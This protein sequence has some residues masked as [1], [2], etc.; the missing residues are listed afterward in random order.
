M[1]SCFNTTARGP[2]YATGKN[3]TTAWCISHYKLCMLLI[4]VQVQV[5]SLRAYM[6]VPW[7]PPSG[8]LRLHTCVPKH[9]SPPSAHPTQS[10]V[11]IYHESIHDV[12]TCQT[13]HALTCNSWTWESNFSFSW[14]C[15]NSWTFSCIYGTNQRYWPQQHVPNQT[16]EGLRMGVVIFTCASCSVSLIQWIAYLQVV[17]LG[18]CSSTLVLQSNLLLGHLVPLEGCR[19][20]GRLLDC[21]LG[22]WI[23]QVPL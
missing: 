12:G 9:P 22:L 17:Y 5:L 7:G 16:M 11:D 3:A 6:Y 8:T 18:L 4:F 15:T 20:E 21:H 1:R 23:N 13:V 10:T 19:G 14:V 2:L